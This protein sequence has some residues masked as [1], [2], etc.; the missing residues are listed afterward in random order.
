MANVLILTV[1]PQVQVLQYGDLLP[2]KHIKEESLHFS[3]YQVSH[4]HTTH[5]VSL[6]FLLN[7]SSSGSDEFTF[8]SPDLH[9]CRLHANEE[10]ENHTYL[11]VM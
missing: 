11:L 1:Q 2:D 3:Y 7:I 6:E 4:R 9:K 8:Y 5:F 10:H